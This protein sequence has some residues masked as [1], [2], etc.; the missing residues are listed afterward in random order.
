MKFS[1]FSLKFKLNLLIMY[2]YNFY[3]YIYIVAP[4]GMFGLCFVFRINR[5]DLV[6]KPGEL[7]QIMTLSYTQVF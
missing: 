7:L 1:V 6:A 2:L 3:I 4:R 5:I